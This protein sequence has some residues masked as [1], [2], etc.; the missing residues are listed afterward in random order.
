MK[1]RIRLKLN[2]KSV[3]LS[4]SKSLYKGLIIWL[5]NTWCL[6]IVLFG[7]EAIE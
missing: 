4:V 1:H 2:V 7:A 3:S 5:E 6:W